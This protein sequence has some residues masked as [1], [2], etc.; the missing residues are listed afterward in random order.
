MIVINLTD[1]S[2]IDF[3]ITK[4]IKS[5]R[6]V[7]FELNNNISLSCKKWQKRHLQLKGYVSDISQK[8]NKNLQD[9]KFIVANVHL[10][11]GKEYDHNTRD[12]FIDVIGWNPENFAVQTGNLI[13]FVKTQDISIEISSR[14]GNKFLLKLISYSDG[15]L[16]MPDYGSVST[17]GFSEWIAVFLWK[18]ALKKAFRLGLPKQYV[19]KSED[20]IKIRGNIDIND[21]INRQAREG[22]YLCN[23]REHDYNNPVN[24]L[25]YYV[26]NRLNTKHNS[27][28]L[29]CFRIGGAFASGTNGCLPNLS[30]ALATKRVTNPYYNDYNRVIELSKN[31][32]RS[33]FGDISNSENNT[34]AF[35]FDVSM[36]FEFFIR[37]VLVRHGFNL[38]Q[39]DDKQFRTSRGLG[40]DNDYHLKPDIIVD[41]GDSFGVFDVKYKN[42][43]FTYGVKREDLFQLHTY[44]GNLMNHKTVSSCGI[45][46]PIH[47]SRFEEFK[48]KK[49]HLVNNGFI[50]SKISIDE[51]EIDFFVVFFI[52]PN[53][54]LV[55]DKIVELKKNE[56]YEQTFRNNIKSFGENFPAVNYIKAATPIGAVAN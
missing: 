8:I 16:E 53:E 37:K 40:N 10:F 2:R 23:Y 27:L 43:D 18:S 46:Y 44:V 42:F 13:G 30:D 17:N 45:I 14:F 34:S 49:D 38:L 36:L 12:N 3:I 55:N 22:K 56:E 41:Y 47:Q 52:V 33:N 5:V 7:F 15:F 19:N 48:D 20:L 31:I 54:E 39:K 21:Y 9:E 51:K 6:D 29:D 25:I 4:D 11:G 50:H 32:L 28:I 1:N 24:R 35:L 26:F